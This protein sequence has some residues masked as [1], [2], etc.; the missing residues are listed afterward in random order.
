M[1]NRRLRSGLAL[2]ILAATIVIALRV[3]VV[4]RFGVRPAPR[5]LVLI[6]IDTLRADRLGSYGH[7]A[8]QTPHLDGLA[9]AG[10]RFSQATTVV[11]LTLPAHS[12]LLTGTFP[13]WHG[14]R[15]NGGFYLGD[16]HVT[17]AEVLRENGF[18]T[19]GFVAAF[20]LDRRWG[21]AQGF[22][23]F[24]DNFDFEKFDNA[25]SMDY[26]QRPGAEVVDRALAWIAEDRD[27]P[28]FA[29]VHLYD[30][31]TPYQAPEPYRSR[32]PAT[33]H[34]AYDAEVAAT[35][36]QVGRLLDALATSGR[37][38]QTLVIVVGDHGEMLGE[39]GEQ[40]HGFFIYDAAVRI[41]LI[42]AG[43]DVPVR[44]VTDQ[45]RI[46]DVMPTALD[47]LGVP[48]PK[49]VQ[50]AS[51]K[52]LTL[53]TR[54][55]LVAHTETWLP[56]YHYGWSE[57]QS[58]QDGRFKYIRAPQPELYDLQTDPGETVNL[59]VSQGQ[60]VAAFD[61]ALSAMIAETSRSNA[62]DRPRRIDPEVE[63]RLMALGYVGGGGSS[64]HLDDRP[65]GDP[66]DKITLYT[67]L[68]Q[69]ASLSLEGRQQE[70]IALVTQALA[71]DPEIV[72]GYMLLGNFQK[73]AKST[74]AAIESYRQALARDPEHLNALFSLAIAFMD[75]GRLDE[76]RVGFERARELDPRNGRVLF[77]L[78][79]IWMRQGRTTEAEAVIRDALTREVD[80]PRFLLKL[81][82]NYITASRF[83]DAERALS[84]ALEKKPDLLTARFN[85]GLVYE[86]RGEIDKAIAA[87]RG[88]L[89]KS[90]AAFRAAF[91][92]AKLLQRKGQPAE[93]LD[94]F[95]QVTAHAP[96]FGTGQLYLAKALLD[97]GDL[98]GAEEWA[99]K[100]LLTKP[101]PAIAPLGHYVLSDVYNRQGR[102]KAAEQE[103]VAAK[104]LRE[105][106]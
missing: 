92:L 52:P 27:R 14:V 58:V 64:R 69:A 57:L 85:L 80:R 28:F 45:V 48:A 93:A 81:G 19:G 56:R 39:H 95:R 87:Y 26:I 97:A 40:Q 42:I 1:R 44:Q 91:N 77:N 22:D 3:G 94:L 20:V 49:D 68:K 74:D 23:R 43:P 100:G 90:P 61:R 55:D 60:R 99:R 70:A 106:S 59:A 86:K 33:M 6:S 9:R 8:A 83:D 15:D 66:K 104:R 71:E 72:E 30:P 4:S 89:D 63:E 38:A 41:P 25:P 29:F 76:A 62:P 36:A 53:G 101:D 10:M 21:I 103:L 102:F 24:F 2:G 50:G 34:G 31:H 96:D 79:D 82:E 32:F 46:V 35:D 5:N 37:L 78:A 17:L 105:R 54:L 84:E 75:A 47:F 88:E 73:K 67:L 7:A 51:L 16:E 12:S 65:R 13:S 18:R 11:P 98:A